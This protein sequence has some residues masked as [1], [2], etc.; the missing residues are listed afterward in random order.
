MSGFIGPDLVDPHCLWFAR[1][2]DDVVEA[3]GVSLKQVGRLKE[4]ANQVVA[5]PGLG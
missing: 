2:A 4:V 3:P 1:R 5:S